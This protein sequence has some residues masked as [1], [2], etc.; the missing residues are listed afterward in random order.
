M[1]YKKWSLAEKLEILTS[2]E[3]IGIV[4]GCRIARK[5]SPIA[6]TPV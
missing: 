5:I 1:K 3:N 4:E 6:I 2:S